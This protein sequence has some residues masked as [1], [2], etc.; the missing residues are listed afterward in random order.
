MRS[1]SGLYYFVRLL[2]LITAYLSMKLSTG[3]EWLSDD[4]WFPIGTVFLTMAIVIAL[5][6]PY[7]KNYM[8]TLDVLLLS[9]LALLSYAIIS[10]RFNLS[11]TIPITMLIPIVVFFLTFLLR[12]MVPLVNC[13]STSAKVLINIQKI[14]WRSVCKSAS[15]NE[16]ECLLIHPN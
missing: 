16:G 11:L 10:S 3:G 15:T 6:K 8:N 13:L 4:M 1:F 2:V 5:T 12:L 9:N 7:K 14:L